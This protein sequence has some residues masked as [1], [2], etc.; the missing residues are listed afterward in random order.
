MWYLETE[1]PQQPG[2]CQLIKATTNSLEISW[3]QVSNAD[4]Y[5]LQIQRYDAPPNT[6][7]QQA[8]SNINTEPIAKQQQQ[9]LN[10]QAQLNNTNNKS[11]APVITAQGLNSSTIQQHPKIVQ[12]P[13]IKIVQKPN[14]T[15]TP[16]LQPT[17]TTTTTTQMSG[18]AAL[19][20][21][22]CATQKI[23]APGT[24]NQAQQQQQTIRLLANTSTTQAQGKPQQ[25]MMTSNASGAQFMT[26]VKTANGQ[27]QL[28]PA[29]SRNNK[30]GSNATIVKLINNT[31]TNQ[32][33]GANIVK[34]ST[35]NLGTST[36]QGTS[37]PSKVIPTIIKNISTAGNT[38][39]TQNGNVITS[40][41][42]Q[43]KTIII[44]SKSNQ[45]IQLQSSSATSSIVSITQTTPTL[46][47][48]S[49]PVRMVTNPAGMKMLVIQAP[50]SQ[51]QNQPTSQQLIVNQAGNVS[52]PFTLQLPNTSGGK[53]ITIP[54]SALQKVNTSNAS[55]QTSTGQKIIQLSGTQL[56]SGMLPQNVRFVTAN[57]NQPKIVILPQSTASNAIISSASTTQQSTSTIRQI[58]TLPSSSVISTASTTKTTQNV[59][60]SNSVAEKSE[61]KITQLDGALDEDESP[62]DSTKSKAENLKDKDEK[63]DSKD[64]QKAEEEEE[65]K[66][67][68]DSELKDKETDESKLSSI[69]S[70]TIKS[71]SLDST[72]TKQQLLL[73]F[74][75]PGLE[76]PAQM[77]ADDPEPIPSSTATVTNSISTSS[78]SNSNNLISSLTVKTDLST[79]SSTSTTHSTQQETN[80]DPLSTLA[81]AAVSSQSQQIATN[82]DSTT[83]V[84]LD[85]NTND[86]KPINASA[87]SS[88]NDTISSVSPSAIK[89]EPDS[90]QSAIGNTEN[91]ENKSSKLNT[92]NNQQANAAAIHQLTKKNQWYDVCSVQGNVSNCIV[93][94]YYIPQP[95]QS[96][97]TVNNEVE[98]FKAP[99]YSQ[100]IKVDLEAGTAY[101][102]RIAAVNSCGRGP[103]SEISAF[104]TYLPGY[105]GPPS[106]IKISKNAD[107]ANL[108]WEAHEMNSSTITEYIVHLGIKNNPQINGQIGNLNNQQPPNK[109][110]VVYSGKEP[111]CTVSNFN[112][113]QAHIDM[114]PKPAI[115]FRIAAKNQLGFGPSTQ[116]RWLQDNSAQT[117][118][119]TSKRQS[120]N[121]K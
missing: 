8:V 83:N 88:S 23:Q 61:S 26:L 117:N 49:V 104:K 30:L 52:Q 28:T 45:P 25:L 41:V 106:D 1:K 40:N 75:L 3:G 51:S 34:T 67:D 54:A 109:F 27:L 19:A 116:V 93:S 119:K 120:A 84:K 20:A 39:Q 95:D 31:A 92:T 76:P 70:K 15:S 46:N 103:W 12:Q 115:I 6:T 16:T 66:M 112:L 62:A 29:T 73:N 7:G 2:K 14:T 110:I 10:D 64:E 50:T 22:A 89:K 100:L 102:L 99:N 69:D 24:P 57:Q 56:A 97:T 53:T 59:I 77:C 33:S 74:D 80:T 32:I 108:S 94:H 11:P 96:T 38:I 71:E 114:N 36:Q 17:T 55:L 21:A 37:T 48:T 79:T 72:D 105:P 98:D 44:P 68:V 35:A 60:T 87:K 91:Q 47:A 9:Q 82:T 65:N 42:G 18:M 13:Q 111:N 5:V 81:S 90:Q 63:V 85:N 86:T 43:S 113:G 4:G 78:I 121:E 107:G 101:K 58:V 118:V